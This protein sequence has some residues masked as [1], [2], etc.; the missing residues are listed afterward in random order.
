MVPRETAF[1]PEKELCAARR[2]AS[3]I[4]GLTFCSTVAASCVRARLT[5]AEVSLLLAGCVV[6]LGIDCPFLETTVC[7]GYLL[8]D[9]FLVHREAQA[10]RAGLEC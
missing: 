1:L 5:V 6:F 9:C 8:V 10:L 4:V 3:V 7:S 2:C